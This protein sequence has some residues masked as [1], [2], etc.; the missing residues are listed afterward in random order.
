[1]TLA[2]EKVI[3]A[4]SGQHMKLYEPHAVSDAI[5]TIVD[6]VRSGVRPR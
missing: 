2:T 3:V 6:R 5:V 4:D 1:V